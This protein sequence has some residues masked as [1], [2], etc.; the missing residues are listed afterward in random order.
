M[1]TSND[2]IITAHRRGY[3]VADDGRL[4]NPAGIPLRPQRNRDGYLWFRPAKAA[5]PVRVH[6][7]QA[8]QRFGAAMFEPGLQVRHL[9]GDRGN[10]RPENIA[11][12]T[13]AENERDKPAGVRM[14]AA[15]KA[16]DAV[17][18]HDH[19]AVAEYLATGATYR[20][21]MARFGISSKATVSFIARKSMEAAKRHATTEHARAL[22][23]HYEE[24][25]K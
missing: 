8:F 20:Q 13:A 3:R 11:L 1:T 15:L 21:A 22:A 18:R 7:L 9:D 10:N 19:A 23:D 4:L 14:A 6:R 12:G 5:P 24:A 25:G 16:T 2:W 17:R